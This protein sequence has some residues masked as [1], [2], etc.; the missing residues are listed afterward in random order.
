L[1]APLLKWIRFYAYRE[2]QYARDGYKDIWERPEIKL[3]KLAFHKEI[4]QRWPEELSPRIDYT[5]FL[6]RLDRYSEAYEQFEL[7]GDRY[8][9]PSTFGS[10]R[11]YNAFRAYTAFKV[12]DDTY[13]DR[14]ERIQHLQEAIDIDD[15]QGVF[16][17][18]LAYEYRKANDLEMTEQLY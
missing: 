7:L 13:T 14:D 5:Y 8:F 18:T 9:H 10:L 16:W 1:K 2:M 12:A 11:Y 3:E 17:F 15:T 6:Y 4:M